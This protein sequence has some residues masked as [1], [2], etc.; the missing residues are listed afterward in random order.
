[1]FWILLHPLYH[2]DVILHNCGPTKVLHGLE[3]APN[4]PKMTSKMFKKE[5]AGR[6]FFHTCPRWCQDGSQD[7]IWE[8]P[9]TLLRPFCRHLEVPGRHFGLPKG[10]LG[11]QDGPKTSCWSPQGPT[12]DHYIVILR[13]FW[14]HLIHLS[15]SRVGFSWDFTDWIIAQGI[16]FIWFT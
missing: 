4:G 16:A 9:M 5:G 7:V 12:R 11:C 13:P 6:P 15:S 1:M 2:V 3:I 8:P 14:T 10:S